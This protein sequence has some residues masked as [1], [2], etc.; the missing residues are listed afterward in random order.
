MIQRPFWGVCGSILLKIRSGINW[1]YVKNKM[2]IICLN[3][4]IRALEISTASQHFCI[5]FRHSITLD[6]SLLKFS[7]RFFLSDIAECKSESHDCHVNANCINTLG[8][9]NCS[10]WPGYKGNG[11]ICAGTMK[12]LFHSSLL[13]L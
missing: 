1:I 2:F 4:L 10:C 3:L 12:Q 13:L 7:F 8:S 9:Y 6:S 11:T 5:Y